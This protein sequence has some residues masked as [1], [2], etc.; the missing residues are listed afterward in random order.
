MLSRPATLGQL[1][2]LAGQP[3][4]ATF[5][6]GVSVTESPVPVHDYKESVSGSSTGEDCE[7]TCP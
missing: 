4:V 6:M 2:W 5:W 3:E 7:H 1:S